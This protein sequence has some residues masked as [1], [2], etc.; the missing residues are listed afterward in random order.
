MG[1][2]VEKPFAG[3]R[4]SRARFW[5]FIRS[6]LRLASRKWPPRSDAMR[7]ARR[8]HR[9]TNKR[10]K[11]EYQCAQCSKWFKGS[12]VQVDHIVPCGKLREFDDLPAFVRR[13]FCEEDNL[14]VLC[15]PCHKGVAQNMT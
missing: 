3:Q 8:C 1:R 12:E 13:L 9:G 5:G 7:A 4:W 11:W 6:A 15:K 10:Q 2:K 14:R